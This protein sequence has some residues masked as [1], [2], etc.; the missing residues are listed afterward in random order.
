MKTYTIISCV[1]R[2]YDLLDTV[3]GAVNKILASANKT[4]VCALKNLFF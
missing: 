2:I 4:K 1:L 3:L